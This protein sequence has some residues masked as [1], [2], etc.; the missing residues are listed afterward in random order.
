MLKCFARNRRVSQHSNRFAAVRAR[1]LPLPSLVGLHYHLDMTE[2]AENEN[3]LLAGPTLRVLIVDND[4]ALAQAMLESLDREGYD[5]TVA[6]SG[7]EGARLIEEECF[8]L[9]VTDMVMNEVDGMAILAKA[10]ELLPDCEVIMVTG[11]ATVPTAVEAM[12][13]A[14]FNFLEKP[15]TPKR[16]RTVVDKAAVA[17]RL[18]HRN[19]E[20]HQRL[21]ERFGFEGIIF[22]SER[23]KQVLERVK[24]IAPT[25]AS[26]FISGESGTGKELI[27][28]AIHQNSL[29]KAKTLYPLNARAVSEQLVESELFGHVKGAYTDARSDRAGAF[30]YA[31]GGT[32]FFDEVADMPMSTQIKLLRVLEN[33]EIKRLGDNKPI[34]VNVRILSATNK[35]LEQLVETGEFREDLYFRLNVFPITS[36]PL[37]ERKDDIALLAHHFLQKSARKANKLGAKI[38]ISDLNILESYDWPGNIRELENLIERQVILSSGDSIKFN[39]LR[40]AARPIEKPAPTE[41]LDN[42]PCMSHWEIREIEKRN[43]M[44]ALRTANGKVF[45]RAGAAEM[46]EIKPTTLASRLKKLNIDPAQFKALES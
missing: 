9:V 28:Q 15:V 13:H 3:E 14:A 11:H 6:T 10:K 17:I 23:M 40:H 27:A 45:G 24:R 22:A 26:V 20:L 29:R 19:Q 35:S 7:P 32:I 37:R 38:S 4:E 43:L 5:C 36:A 25:D 21:D 31:N 12:Q 18:R 30:E 41:S 16:L 44:K 1:P 2:T 33:H 46:L 8:D 42:R 34:K 39:E